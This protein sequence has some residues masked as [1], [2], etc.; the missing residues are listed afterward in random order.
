[1]T[2]LQQFLTA[3]DKVQ[4][5]TLRA[6]LKGDFGSVE[7]AFTDAIT[8]R[9]KAKETNRLLKDFKS[10]IGNSLGLD[11]EYTVADIQG[12]LSNNNQDLEKLK[13]DISS[14]YENDLET[15]RSELTNRE[16]SFNEL[17]G[18]YN[19]TIFNNTITQ[20][21]LLNDFVDEPMA[22]NLITGTIK[23]KLLFEDGQIFVKDSSTGEKA[24]DIRTGEFLKADSVI[25]DIKSTISPMYLKADVIAQGGG[26]PA[27]QA[28]PTTESTN[29]KAEAAKQSGDLSGFISAQFN[30]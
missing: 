27:N 6:E 24:K 12:K 23:E 25:N 3:L 21:G 16:S 8:T 10:E 11:K 17:T 30:N 5:E 29:N 13:T 7:G 19:E 4:D 22:R 26:A 15:L 9:D 14:K 1:M 28:K 18:K 20:S 2:V